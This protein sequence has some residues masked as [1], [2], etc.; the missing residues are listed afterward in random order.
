MENRAE[1]MEPINVVCEN[2]ELEKEQAVITTADILARIDQIIEQGVVM[3]HAVIQIK[4]LPVNE[5]PDGGLDGAARAEAIRDIHVQREMTNRQ[6]IS[7]LN[8]M[9]DDIAPKQVPIGLKER[10]IERL[11]NMGFSGVEPETAKVIMDTLNSLLM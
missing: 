4:E 8:R 5:C 9:Y 2:E 10:A 6:I 1:N 7:L 3:Q 11:S